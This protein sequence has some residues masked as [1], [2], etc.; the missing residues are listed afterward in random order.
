MPLN[1]RKGGEIL[2]TFVSEEERS[3]ATRRRGASYTTERKIPATL[4]KRGPALRFAVEGKEEENQKGLLGSPVGA[5]KEEEVTSLLK[6]AVRNF[7]WGGREEVVQ[8][9]GES[10]F[11][12]EEKGS[13]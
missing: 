10:S 1:G 4:I 5:E 3:C 2:L 6:I 13:L 7:A 11:S 9:K 8:R 12:K